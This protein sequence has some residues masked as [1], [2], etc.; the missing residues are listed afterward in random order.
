MARRARACHAPCEM[1]PA[2][3]SSPPER[4]DGGD[5][6]G[7]R[8]ALRWYLGTWKAAYWRGV[9]AAACVGGGF[10]LQEFAVDAARG[11]AADGVS[12]ESSLGA[13]GLWALPAALLLG[14][15]FALE[16][17]RL[18][19]GWRGARRLTGIALPALAAL[20]L[21]AGRVVGAWSA[22]GA[23]ALW[24]AA[25]VVAAFTLP[26][27]GWRAGLWLGGWTAVALWLLLRHLL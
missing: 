16:G 24:I 22:A 12:W 8:E 15:G 23:T 1:G 13:F 21:G 14:A 27:R 3:E 20:L 7:L 6:P 25:C 19:P 10:A 4:A 18:A 11:R 5:A 26:V 9:V 17:A 2:G